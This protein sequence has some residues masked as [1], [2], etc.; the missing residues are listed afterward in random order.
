MALL[1][2]MRH[3]ESEWNK[4]NQFTG[5]V[6]I[7]LSLKGIEEAINGGKKIKDLPIDVIIMTTLIRSQMT[8]MLAMSQH[9]SGKTPLVVHEGDGKFEDWGKIHSPEAASQ[10]IPCIRCWELNE[11]MYGSLQG[12]NKA[13]LAE[14]YGPEQVK[15]WRRSYDTAPPGG[16]SLKLT[17]ERSIPYFENHIVPLLKA[18][19]NVFI[20]AH[21]NSLRAIIMDL[22]RLSESQVVQ[23]EIPTGEPIV[24]TYE[25]GV[26]MKNPLKA[27]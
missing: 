21:G 18:G 1:I 22:D 19:K 11:R 4:R 5:W 8:A 17:A 9:S 16:E 6:D 25:N 23:L 15:I 12:L 20:S 13:E 7:P 14:K 3:G 24:Y 27:V 2:M 10:C 26:F